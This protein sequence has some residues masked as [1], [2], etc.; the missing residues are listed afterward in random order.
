[1]VTPVDNAL[2]SL[3]GNSSLDNRCILRTMGLVSLP[4]PAVQGSPFQ[5]RPLATFSAAVL[6]TTEGR[7][8]SVM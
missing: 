4:S 7:R 3:L 6:S 5:R 2:Q 8:A 1:M